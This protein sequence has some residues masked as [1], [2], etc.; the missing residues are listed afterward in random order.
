[1]KTLR[2]LLDG[3]PCSW[4]GKG[5]LNTPIAYVRSDSRQIKPGD[6]FVAITGLH[7]DGHQFIKEAI[8]RG[9]KVVVSER[10]DRAA[11]DLEIPQFNV[12]KSRTALSQL[13]ACAYDFPARKL[14]CIGITGT[15]G[16]TTTAFLVQYLLNEVTRAGLVGS[17]YYD[18][19]EIKQVAGNTTPT[20]EVLNEIL[21]RM[22]ANNISYCVMEISSHALDQDRIQGFEFSSAIFTNLTQDHLDYHH[23]YETYYQAKRKLFFGSIPP[24]HSIINR[25]TTFGARLIGEI[26]ETSRVVSYGFD[27]P[28]DYLAEEVQLGWKG[29][30]FILVRDKNRFKVHAPLMLRHN[31]YNVLAALSTISEEGFSLNELIPNLVH[32]QG[33]AGRM[34]PIDEG[35]DFRVFVDFAHT[36]DGLFNVL[37]SLEGLKRNRVIS[38]FGCG[39]DR[40]QAKRPMMGGIANQL[41]DVVILTSDNPR[42]ERPEDILDHIRS[43]IH[44]NGKKTQLF[45][46]PDRKEAIRY[47]IELAE[48][49]DVVFI[50]GKGHEH[51]QILGKEKIPFSDQQIARHW[52]KVRCSHLRKSQKLAV[53]G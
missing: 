16:K 12:S 26:K 2:Q 8:R 30:D 45:V 39:G 51:Y 32:F 43:G 31:V 4:N 17:I 33:V 14:K 35:Q 20:P 48:T 25:D 27:P 44:Q 52:L 9:A 21:S 47:A 7:L 24:Q 29:L 40:D 49:E 34:E 38:V 13:V 37:S 10:F 46:R 41:S 3:I 36:P 23:D 18:D 19:G 53:E 11:S 42:S 15:N 1:M 5:E 50:F 6:L 22:V 28:R